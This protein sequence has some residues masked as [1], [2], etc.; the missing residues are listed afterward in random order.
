MECG[1]RHKHP[2]TF[3]VVT[4]QDV[5]SVAVSLLLL[6]LHVAGVVEEAVVV[7][8]SSMANLMCSPWKEQEQKELP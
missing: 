4:S 3:Q 5:C 6:L 1:T 7:S 2:S 8:K